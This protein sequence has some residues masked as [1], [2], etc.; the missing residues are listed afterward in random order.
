MAYDAE[1]QPLSTTL[2]EYLM[3]TSMEA[4]HIDVHLACYPSP[5]NPLGVKGVGE[6]G[7]V[8]STA[9]VVSAVENALAAYGVRLQ[10]YP[11]TPTR[12][13][14]ALKLARAAST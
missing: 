5:L 7:C 11:V 4:P 2:A 9:A 14:A 1:A 13:F 3:P 10:E 12:L 8:P 6:A